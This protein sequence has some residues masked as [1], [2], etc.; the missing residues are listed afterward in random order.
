[1]EEKIITFK[2]AMMETQNRTVL[3]VA[4][5]VDRPIEKVWEY[6]TN[7]DHITKWN[8]A[9]HD[10][11]TPWAKNDLRKGGN[12]SSRMEAKDG[13]MGFEFG[14]VYDEVRKHEYIEYTLGDGRK[15]NLTFTPGAGGT[16]VTEN[17]EAEDTNSLELQ[18]GGWQSILDNF[19]KYSEALL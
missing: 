14:G 5:L 15:V 17:F 16:Q 19:K 11:H 4:T 10:W 9:S 13:S 6:W 18:Q 12:F 7:P 1:M 3:T 8:N 2:I